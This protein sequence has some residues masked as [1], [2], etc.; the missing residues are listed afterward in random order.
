MPPVLTTQSMLAKSSKVWEFERNVEICCTMVRGSQILARG[1]DNGGNHDAGVWPGQSDRLHRF[2]PERLGKL[3]L[4]DCQSG[5]CVA[6]SRRRK[7]HQR[8]FD[9]LAGALS[10]PRRARW[11]GLHEYQLL[12]Q[13]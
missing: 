4:G 5:Q 6:R 3:E 10:A 1:N 11:L 13:R 9:Q 2:A 12:D 8:F 7:L